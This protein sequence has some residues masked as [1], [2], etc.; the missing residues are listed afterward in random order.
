VDAKTG[1]FA[2][3]PKT[4]FFFGKTCEHMEWLRDKIC[5]DDYGSKCYPTP[6]NT[7]TVTEARVVTFNPETLGYESFCPEAVDDSLGRGRDRGPR[8]RGR[9]QS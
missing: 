9:G 1:V 3:T 8:P 4:R 6:Q 5:Y 2:L 7:Y